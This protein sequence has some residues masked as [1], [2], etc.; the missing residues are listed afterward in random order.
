MYLRS[1]PLD[2]IEWKARNLRWNVRKTEKFEF[3]QRDAALLLLDFR[4]F[5]YVYIRISWMMT[6]QHAVRKEQVQRGKSDAT[7]LDN[8]CFVT[9]PS[10]NRPLLR[11]QCS[12]PCLSHLEPARK[13]WPY[14]NRL[15]Q[16]IFQRYF[17]ISIS[18]TK[19]LMIGKL[20]KSYSNKKILFENERISAIPAI[21][22]ATNEIE[23]LKNNNNMANHF[24][25]FFLSFVKQDTS[26]YD[27]TLKKM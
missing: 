18:I 21:S 19:L 3:W 8:N 5:A 10:R 7:Q 6:R 1:S 23:P 25:S 22:H 9:F 11:E 20:E 16:D 12:R 17:R 13:H 14:R 24:L 2:N 15:P 4:S 26:V 27:H